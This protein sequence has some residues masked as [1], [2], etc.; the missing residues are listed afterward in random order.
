MKMNVTKK[1]S[2]ICLLGVCLT[3]LACGNPLSSSKDEK[4]PDLGESLSPIEEV[5]LIEGADNTTLT[6][7]MNRLKNAYFDIE[8]SNIKSNEIIGDGVRDSWCID[9]WKS[10]DSNNGVYDNIKLYSTYLV[11]QWKPV[12]YLLNVQKSLRNSDSQITWLE[13]QLAIWSLRAYPKF[14]LDTTSIDNLPGQF[15]K[16][17]E[18]LFSYDKVYEILDFVEAN[19]KSF[20]FE[21]NGTK[22][23]VVAEMPVDVQ[24][25]ITTAEK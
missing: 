17:G 22:F 23:A 10:I 18:A 25:V 19:Y 7:N 4:K 1:L 13:I 5:S 11:E 8:F 9:V 2:T 3:F 20:N 21:Q 6:I 24:T 16:D 12:N 14:D 15:R